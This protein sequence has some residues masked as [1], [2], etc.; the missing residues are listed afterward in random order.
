M[1]EPTTGTSAAAVADLR[2]AQR[3]LAEAERLAGTMKSSGPQ[4]QL[5]GEVATVLVELDPGDAERIARTIGRVSHRTQVLA[6][7]AV[8]R[9]QL[10]AGDAERLARTITGRIHRVRALAGIARV[11]IERVSPSSRQ[12]G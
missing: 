5:L 3:L 4:F 8:A 2:R 9:A 6:G 11:L 7:V 10:D 12:A 1:T